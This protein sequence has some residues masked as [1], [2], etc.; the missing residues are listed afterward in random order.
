MP[1]FGS[2]EEMANLKISKKLFKYVYKM[3]DDPFFWR[4]NYD[5]DKLDHIVHILES[6]TITKRKKITI[7]FDNDWFDLG[8]IQSILLR[9]RIRKNAKKM[10]QAQLLIRENKIIK[11]V[12]HTFE[13]DSYRRDFREKVEWLKQNGIS[14]FFITD[15]QIEFLNEEDVMAFKIKFI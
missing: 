13:L 4:W 12:H 15:N 8:L 3:F 11:K 10:E 9:F 1:A 14:N 6:V 5:N 2:Y 7:K